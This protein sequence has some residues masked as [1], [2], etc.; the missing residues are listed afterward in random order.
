MKLN[1]GVLVIGA[2]PAGLAL[3]FELK[4]RGVECLILERG[5]AP[6]ESW[7]QMPAR[8][9]LVSP[10]KAN[11]LSGTPPG[12]FPPHHE[13]T[14]EEF[15]CYLNAYARDNELPVQTGVEVR[16]VEREGESCFRVGTSVGEFSSHAVV[17][18]T[19]YYSNPFVPRI[20]G[21]DATRVA[22]IHVVGFRDAGNIRQRL[23]RPSG[24]V[25]IVGQRLSAGQTIVELVDAGFDVALS[26]RSPIR[27]G[28]GPLAWWF[29][30]R[31][32]P[33]L[34]E[35]KLK[36]HG[37]RAPANDVKMQGGRARELIES[38]AVKTFPA[39][40]RFEH[41][42]VVFTD[43]ATQQPDLVIHATGF[44]PALAHLS[45]LGLELDAASGLPTLRE[46]ESVSVPGLFFLG[47]DGARNF[48]SRFLRSI[49]KDARFLAER[50]ARSMHA[51]GRSH[52]AHE[53]LVTS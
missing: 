4:Q 33:W 35:L 15:L 25:L 34:E 19:G 50:I 12:L 52:A 32:F 5:S 28:A 2:G 9:K 43:G 51:S 37:N 17:N 36:R 29:L 3:G 41:D 10:W 11:R 48:Q 40:D 8:L 7:R 49:R 31:M 26:H 13:T 14:R 1:P 6:G 45:S 23:G 22:Q 46:L 16:A 38:G 20:T 47:L 53:S 27:F 18:A 30:F 24:L 44:R 39:I 21:A 42:A